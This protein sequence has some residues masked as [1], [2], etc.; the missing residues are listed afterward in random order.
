MSSYAVIDS[1]KRDSVDWNDVLEEEGYERW[2]L[3]GSKFLVE[4]PGAIPTWAGGETILTQETAR[5]RV[6]EEF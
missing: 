2:S 3:D 5:Q 1:S 6:A 4:F